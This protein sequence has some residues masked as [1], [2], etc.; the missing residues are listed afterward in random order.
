MYASA[1][2]TVT[3][4]TA[5]NGSWTVGGENGGGAYF[6]GAATL[7][8]MHILSNTVANYGAGAYFNSAANITG[9]SFRNNQSGGLA[10][11]NLRRRLHRSRGRPIPQVRHDDEV[12]PDLLRLQNYKTVWGMAKKYIKNDSLRRVFSF[13]PLLVGG[14][15]F[16]TTSIYSLIFSSSASGACSSPWAGRARSS[17][18]WR[19]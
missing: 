10:A 5:Q 13:Q 8:G 15:P 17:A 4:L 2:L 18:G 19:S 16:N 3:N 14:N 6:G 7:S 1:A 12:C 11:E 9:G